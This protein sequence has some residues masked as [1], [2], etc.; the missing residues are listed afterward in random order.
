MLV[1]LIAGEPSGDMLGARLMRALK[2]LEPNIEFAGVGGDNME[3]EGMTSL[4]DI[5]DLSIMGLIEVIPSIPKVLHH[6]RETVEDIKEKQ[7]D[8]VITIDSWSFSARIHKAIRKKNINIW[9]FH[10]VAPQVWAW[11]KGRAKTMHKYI[12]H[13]LTLFPNE[14]AYFTPYH[15]PTDFVGHPV[16]ESSMIEANSHDFIQKYH[17]ASDQKV[18]LLL[19]GSRHNEVSHLL[20]IFLETAAILKKRHPE[21]FFV[22]PTVKT[23]ETRV[24]DIIKKAQSDILVINTQDERY[25]AAH[26]SVAAIAASGT[27][28]LELAIIKVPHLIAYKVPPLTAW[29]VKHLTKIKYVNLTNLILNQPIVPELLQNNCNKETL[30]KT[31]EL[32]LDKNSQCYQQEQ[33]GFLK[34]Q[35]ALGMGKKH[36]SLKAAEIILQKI[37]R[38]KIK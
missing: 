18:I 6:I 38:K 19:P 24:R 26:A 35:E 2:Q 14:P 12:D 15:L 4:F 17:I 8:A 34:L 3:K 31:T 25:S 32:L 37:K 33:D 29:L 11:K 28:A 13:L 7:P 23:V 30:V 16:I 5:S 10:Y 21:L 22:L 36:P 27:V 9:Q 1:Y 20:P